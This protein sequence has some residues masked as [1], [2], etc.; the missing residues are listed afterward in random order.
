MWGM[1]LSIKA[2]Y[3]YSHIKRQLKTVNLTRIQK[4]IND[5]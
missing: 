4:L 3:G 5:S 2:V 1:E